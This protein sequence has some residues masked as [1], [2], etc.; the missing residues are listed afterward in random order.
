MF[1]LQLVFSRSCV[2]FLCES[3]SRL[4]VTTTTTFNKND[5]EQAL[6]LAEEVLEKIGIVFCYVRRTT[7]RVIFKNVCIATS[8]L[9][10]YFLGTEEIDSTLVQKA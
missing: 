5:D 6:K 3:T 7:M 1:F 10:V 9:V 8:E 2:V 4:T